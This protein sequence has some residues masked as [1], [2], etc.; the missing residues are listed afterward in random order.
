MRVQVIALY[1]H[2]LSSLAGRPGV[3]FRRNRKKKTD[4]TLVPCRIETTGGRSIALPEL[5]VPAGTTAPLFKA[6]LTLNRLPVEARRL[7]CVVLDPDTSQPQSDPEQSV[8]SP[9][10][11]DGKTMIFEFRRAM[12]LTVGDRR[13]VEVRMVA[14][15]PVTGAVG[16][17]TIYRFNA[18][19]LGLTAR[20]LEYLSG[21]IDLYPPPARHVPRAMRDVPE[22]EANLTFE[23]W[24]RAR[25]R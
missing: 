15:H 10:F 21:A 3:R 6:Q 12:V 23:P 4:S 19:Y 18:R 24:N 1:P 13:E 16:T 11:D 20:C 25:S 9:I 7:V 2:R 5:D 8:L 17:K 14:V 22:G